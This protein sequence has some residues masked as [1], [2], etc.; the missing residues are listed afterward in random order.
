M[1]HYPKYENGIYIY[2]ENIGIDHPDYNANGLDK[3]YLQEEEH[4]WFI[5][6]KE[7]IYSLMNKYIDKKSKIIDIGSGTGNIPRYLK[8]FGYSN[9]C[10]GDIHLNGLL[11]AKNYGIDLCY[12]FDL[13]KMPFMDDFDTVCMFDVLEH[14]REDEVVIE[15]VYKAL[16]K[17]GT[18]VLTVPAHMWLWSRDDQ[19]AGHK[20]RYTKKNLESKLKANGF[21]IIV[22]EYF[23]IFIVPLLILRSW[24]R[25]DKE[26]KVDISEFENNLMIHPFVNKILLALTRIENKF[27]KWIPNWFGGSLLIIARKNGTV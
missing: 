1:K 7:L 13:L 12:Q 23:F 22:S 18:F 3:I 15:N 19:I 17:N 27:H 2:H 4:F 21:E 8:K 14:I 6:R 10:S 11:Y 25:A 5:C 9:I 20:L 24:I 16:R 26:K